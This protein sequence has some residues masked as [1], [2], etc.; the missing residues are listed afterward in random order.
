VK[1]FASQCAETHPQ[2]D[3]LRRHNFSKN[4]GASNA[5]GEIPHPTPS[6]PPS[7]QG[8]GRA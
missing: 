3:F 7:P 6:G 1:T 4:S 8:G 5:H 2:T